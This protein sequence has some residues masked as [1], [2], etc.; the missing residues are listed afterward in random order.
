MITSLFKCS[1]SNYFKV[2]LKSLISSI[3]VSFSNSKSY[4]ISSWQELSY[5]I[6]PTL[7]LT[8]FVSYCIISFRLLNSSSKRWIYSLQNYRS[9]YFT[10]NFVFSLYFNYIFC[11]LISSKLSLFL[12]IVSSKVFSKLVLV[13]EYLLYDNSKTFSNIL[14]TIVWISE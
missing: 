6:S 9:N 7:A 11:S 13:L 10:F 3:R 14:L 12:Y 2:L 1:F 4:Y 8:L 5:L